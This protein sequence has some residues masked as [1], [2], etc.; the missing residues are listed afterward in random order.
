MVGKIT[1]KNAEGRVPGS[2]GL[3]RGGTESRRGKQNHLYS[4]HQMARKR[5]DCSCSLN[6]TGHSQGPTSS[7][8]N[9]FSSYG[10]RL[11][12]HPCRGL[13]MGDLSRKTTAHQRKEVSPKAA[14]RPEVRQQESTSRML[15][16]Q[17][18]HLQLNG[19]N[20]H[21]GRRTG[22]GLL[23]RRETDLQ[24]P[25]PRDAGAILLMVRQLWES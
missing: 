12:S 16:F 19:E 11:P 6:P 8:Q 14:S 21:R 24:A 25:S 20:S 3:S 4:V 9:S 15:G 13:A 10:R 2:G 18:C 22:D 1:S 7:G 23:V 17:L 5:A